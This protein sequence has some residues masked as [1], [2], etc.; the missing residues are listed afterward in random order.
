M[1]LACRGAV[2]I[3][4][5]EAA[6]AE[7]DL[8]VG[9]DLVERV[10]VEEAE[11]I[12][13]YLLQKLFVRI[14]AASE[15][16]A[17]G[18]VRAEIAGIEELGRGDTHM[19]LCCARFFEQLDDVGDGRAAHDRVVDHDH[20]LARDVAF[21]HVELERDATFA[22]RLR[23]LNER[24]ADIS[25]FD[26]SQAEGDAAAHA[27]TDGA[28]KTA[29]GDA[30]D[31]VRVDGVLLCQKLTRE[32]ARFVDGLTVD[33]AVG[34]GEIDVLENARARVCR[35]KSLVRGE[36]SV[37]K[38]DDLARLD[39]AHK[40]GADRVE[41]AG[42]GGKDVIF[43]YPAHAKRADTEGIAHGDELGGAHDQHGI[44]TSQSGHDL[45]DRFLDAGAVDARLGDEVGDDLGV[46]GGME[47]RA[48]RLKL[49]A[50]FVGVED[51]A[52]MRDRERSFDVGNE[53]RLGVFAGV[54]AD[55]GIADVSQ[56]NAAGHGGEVC[57]GKDV[58]DKT[59]ILFAGD[60]PVLIDGDTAGFLTAV[61][62][63]EKPVVNGFCDV[64]SVFGGIV[65]EHAAFFFKCHKN[66]LP[67]KQ[68][69]YSTPRACM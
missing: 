20:A 2:G 32:H 65:T 17:V 7:F 38:G 10:H 37:M 42:L 36:L 27:V 61:L 55:G 8:G 60:D 50:Q 68:E 45:G 5:R 4:A 3:F 63:G 66:V 48:F 9:D 59:E 64:G 35:A 29:V 46:V 57:V 30:D 34:A 28:G 24:P 31:Q 51:G 40:L 22:L 43:A 25:V 11:R 19:N 23:G 13:V 12:G 47:E 21:E 1:R 44:R 6:L 58:R 62:E 52:V 18:D 26:K 14:F 41:S 56:R 33:D 39:V 15:L 53:K 16:V 69:D 49:S 54:A 67:K